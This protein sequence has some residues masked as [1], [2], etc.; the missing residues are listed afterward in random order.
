MSLETKGSGVESKGFGKLGKATASSGG[1]GGISSER[2][3]KFTDADMKRPIETNRDGI[4]GNTK[5]AARDPGPSGHNVT[6]GFG[7]TVGPS[8]KSARSGGGPI[9]RPGPDTAK[10]VGSATEGGI[11]GNTRDVRR[12]PVGVN[13]IE[14]FADSGTLKAFD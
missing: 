4:L 11:L 10:G 6:E 2:G 7:G 9:E 8:L 12:N 14:G 5:N 1:K 3:A 13:K